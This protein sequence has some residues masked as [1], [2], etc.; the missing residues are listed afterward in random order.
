MKFL[1]FVKHPETGEVPPQS[2]MDAMG[3]LV[4]QAFKS[5]EMIDTGGLAPTA[6]SKRVRLAGG[7]L[8]VLD[9]PFTEAKEVIGG[10]AFFKLKSKE[11]A[12]QRAQEFM[13][14]HRQHWPEWEGEVEIRQI[15][16]PEEFDETMKA[17][18]C[19]A[20]IR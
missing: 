8:R 1:M 15:F 6:H 18:Q 4:E 16:G 13:E 20:S 11:E 14:L 2:L 3:K 19:A 12:L 5:G 7:K 9:G 17:R 10:F